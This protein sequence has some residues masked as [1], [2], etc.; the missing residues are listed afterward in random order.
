[1]IANDTCSATDEL[2]AGKL[3]KVIEE[4]FQSNPDIMIKE[5]NKLIYEYLKAKGNSKIADMFGIINAI[6]VISADEM[7]LD[8]MK[9][10]C[11]VHYCN[12]CDYNINGQC[13][14]KTK[15]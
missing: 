13:K 15:R 2:Y 9:V 1:M 10:W 8:Q 5:V 4:N 6:D 14:L 12:T 11:M 3:E 7:T